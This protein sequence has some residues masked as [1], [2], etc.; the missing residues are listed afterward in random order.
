MKKLFN[1]T[2]AALTLSL[3]LFSASAIAQEAAKIPSPIKIVVPF[4]PGASTDVSAR[5]VASLLSKELGVDVIVENKPGAS[6]MIGARAVVNGA[7]NGSELLVVSNSLITAA[8]T[9]RNMTF[10]VTKDLVPVGVLGEGEMIVTVPANSPIKTPQDLVDAAKANPGKLNYGSAGT[11]TIMHMAVELFAE[12]AGGVKLTH[13]PYKGASQAVVD[14]TAGTLDMLLGA[15]ATFGPVLDAGR[16]RAI[17][18]TTEKPS[19]TFPD[20]P[21]MASA[22]P[23][24]HT[25]IWIALWA[26]AGVPDDVMKRLNEAV[27]K[28]THSDEYAHILTSAG[29]QA[30]RATPAELQERVRKEYD[31]WKQVAKTNNIVID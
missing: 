18:V 13:I 3:S 7:K 24:Y 1:L 11:G 4:S 30:S 12:K 20:L 17:A 2:A 21:T 15:Y 22:A 19:K 29:H 31:A 23:G 28:V 27:V 10:D 9:L 26:P 14:M 5:A 16:A 25:D 6:G 8:A